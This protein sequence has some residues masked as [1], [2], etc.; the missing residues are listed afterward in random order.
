MKKRYAVTYIL[1]MFSMAFIV[2]PV[3][4]EVARQIT[5]TPTFYDFGTALPFCNTAT[6]TAGASATPN[7]SAFIPTANISTPVDYS[8]ALPH[9]CLTATGGNAEYCNTPT[10]GIPSPT[11]TALALPTQTFAPTA[12]AVN[13]S[14]VMAC[15][16]PTAPNMGGSASMVYLNDYACQYTF[17]N[18][19]NANGVFA[20]SIHVNTGTNGTPS[21]HNYSGSVP[22]DFYGAFNLNYSYILEDTNPD[23]SPFS[24]TQL[25]DV[26]NALTPADTTYTETFTATGQNWTRIQQPIFFDDNSNL[27]TG[28]TFGGASSWSNAV[29]VNGTVT[30][31][32]E[33]YSPFA[34]TTPTAMPATV[35]PT[36]TISPACRPFEVSPSI[37]PIAIMDP[38][39][40]RAGDCYTIIPETDVNFPSVDFLP[41]LYL[42]GGF[43]I[44][45]GLL[46]AIIH[47]L[48]GIFHR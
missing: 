48:M 13:H 8:T 34:T 38:V 21:L 31:Y 40:W 10:A 47:Y 24:V 6:P 1:F 2:T 44:G 39:I 14:V 5:A 36:P 9:I 32:L 45:I 15:T 16:A 4:A 22:Y 28:W 41:F 42:I 35:T 26:R 11:L 25:F 12:T 46:L 7:F 17:T 29:I 43:A 3:S 27:A 20:Q 33:G 37:E 30:Y 18:W 19:Q 23:H